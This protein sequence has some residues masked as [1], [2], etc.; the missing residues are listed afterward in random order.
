[1]TNSIGGEIRAGVHAL[2]TRV[3]HEDTDY[4][5][6]VYHA[7]YLRFAERGR[8]DMLR[9]LGVRHE[10]LQQLQ[11][12]VA[13]M[14]YRMEIDFLGAA[15]IAET[16]RVE[17]RLDALSRARMDLLQQIRRGDDLLWRARV[18]VIAATPGE[19]ARRLPAQVMQAFAALQGENRP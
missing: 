1:M 9:L 4:T 2:E 15:R 7:S 17:T 11:P 13:L 18:A 14:V 19:R 10:E 3:Y 8:S 5:G 12:P 6:V 16:L